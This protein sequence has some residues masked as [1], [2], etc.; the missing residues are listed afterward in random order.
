MPNHRL[1]GFCVCRDCLRVNY[2]VD[3]RPPKEIARDFSYTIGCYHVLCH[4]FRRDPDPIFF[5]S[6]HRGPQSQPKK[7][8]ARDLIISLRKQNYSV[9]EISQTLKERNCPLSPTAVRE[10]LK[11]EGFAPLPRR[12][13]EERPDYPRPTV[14]A[15]ADVRD[16]SLS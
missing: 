6:P 7:S 4:H 16:F 3:D 9:H 10:V 13:D 5:V 12:L 8:A 2:F 1:K 14:E 11:V 15:V